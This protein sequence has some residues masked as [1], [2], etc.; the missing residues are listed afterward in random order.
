MAEPTDDDW[1][2]MSKLVDTFIARPDAEPFREP[3]DYKALGEQ[4]I[5]VC[6]YVT[7]R[8]ACSSGELYDPCLAISKLVT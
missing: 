1:K 7:L 6:I 5:V 2:R 3:V 8:Y 4:A